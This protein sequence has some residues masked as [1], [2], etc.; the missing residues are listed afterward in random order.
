MF[1]ALLPDPR[2]AGLRLAFQFLYVRTEQANKQPSLVRLQGSHFY[3]Y[4]FIKGQRDTG[5]TQ[6]HRNKGT[7]HEQRD[8]SGTKEQRNKGTKEQRKLGTWELGNMGTWE[9][10]NLRTWEL[11]NLGTWEFWILD[12]WDLGNLGTWELGDL[13]EL[14]ELG[15]GEVWS[16][17]QIQ[18]FF[19]PVPLDAMCTKWI[20]WMRVV[21]FLS[22]FGLEDATNW[23]KSKQGILS[24]GILDPSY[25][26][27]IEDESSLVIVNSLSLRKCLDNIC[28]NL[29]MIWMQVRA[30]WECCWIWIWATTIYRGWTGLP[31]YSFLQW[32]ALLGW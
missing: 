11:W 15:S 4:T 8:N 13:G 3:P 10:E 2:G 20:I 30:L 5:T 32:C 31:A 14:G 24:K 26:R 17:S 27:D 19:W 1:F 18:C 28:V 16:W 12:P 21:S 6:E 22:Q 23:N 7:T 9:L 29:R 25:F